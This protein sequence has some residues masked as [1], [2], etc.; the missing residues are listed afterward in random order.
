MS[1]KLPYSLTI[2]SGGR[3][4]EQSRD[5]INSASSGQHWEI[6]AGGT[7]PFSLSGKS[8]RERSRTGGLGHHAHVSFRP[9]P[10]NSRALNPIEPND[11]PWSLWINAT[12]HRISIIQLG[13][14]FNKSFKCWII[15]W[16]VLICLE[17]QTKLCYFS[18]LLSQCPDFSI[19]RVVQCKYEFKRPLMNNQREHCK[20][21][22][23]IGWSVRS[24][25]STLSSFRHFD[26]FAARK[27]VNLFSW[28]AVAFFST[29]DAG[30]LI[31]SLRADSF[32]PCASSDSNWC[33][34]MM[35]AGGDE[36]NWLWKRMASLQRPDRNQMLREKKTFPMDCVGCI[37]VHTFG[38]HEP[39]S[40]NRF[41]H[42]G[43][44]LTTIIWSSQDHQHI[45][46]L[47]NEE[48]WCDN[49]HSFR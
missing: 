30:R 49:E 9:W 45:H 1:A 42:S 47:D 23:K 18:V 29:S 27:W 24:S 39:W 40:S 28:N 46:V 38:S 48:R 19:K 43:T 10:I 3:T 14:N 7:E 41:P 21:D 31:S 11:I 34:A 4:S 13:L 8:V 2:A 37:R 35:A 36:L 33:A 20:I 15:Q 25:C 6:L 26:P 32:R 5:A 12:C 17:I 16:K 22:R 44:C